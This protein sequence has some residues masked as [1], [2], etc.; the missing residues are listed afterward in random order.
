IPA[1]TVLGQ[2]HVGVLASVGAFEVV[3]H[4][5]PKVGVLSTGDELV[6]GP[7]RLAPGQIRDSNRR[8][9]LALCQQAGFD[10]VDPGLARDD[11]AD[12]L[13]RPL[14]DGVAEEPLSRRPDGKTHFVLVVATTGED[15]RARVR[16]S[17]GQSSNLLRSMALANALA[18]LPDGPGA[19]AGDVVAVMLL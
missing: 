3:A 13:E 9:L 15:G 1:G 10:A 19:A 16:S 5:R 7:G 11:P 17:G 18:V 8:R 4:P 14:V 6:D 2:G 12:A